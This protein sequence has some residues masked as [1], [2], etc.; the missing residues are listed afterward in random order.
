MSVRYRTEAF[1]GSG[2]RDAVEVMR[3]EIFEL[4]N[5]DILDTLCSGILANHPV[6]SVLDS[7]ISELAKNGYIDGLSEAVQRRFCRE[8]LWA[9]K[10]VT[11]KDVRYALWLT[12]KETIA[13]FY[14]RDMAS[15]DD[16]DAYETGPVMLSGPNGDGDLYGYEVM[17]EPL[18][19]KKEPIVV[20]NSDW[21]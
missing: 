19:I 8:L 4:N 14:G 7:F 3:F 13:S 17:P 2:V 16:Y 1:S 12:D 10:D 11:G 18:E 5:S 20:S 9:V 15:G 6:S 21:G